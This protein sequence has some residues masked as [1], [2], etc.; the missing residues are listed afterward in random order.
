LGGGADTGKCPAQAGFFSFQHA[1]YLQRSD[2]GLSQYFPH[3]L[4]SPPIIAQSN[5]IRFN[6]LLYKG[7]RAAKSFGFKPAARGRQDRIPL[8]KQSC[9]Y[10]VS[11]IYFALIPRNY[12][13]QD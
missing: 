8:P 3:R 9:N 1:T 10:L 4:R 13:R 5:P 2:D 12:Q 11:S 7:G 6:S